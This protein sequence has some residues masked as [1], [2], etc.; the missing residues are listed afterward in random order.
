MPFNMNTVDG[1]GGGGGVYRP[2]TTAIYTGVS[3]MDNEYYSIKVAR[4]VDDDEDD[5]FGG[6]RHQWT[7]PNF[8][9][10][11]QTHKTR[12]NC[13]TTPSSSAASCQLDEIEALVP[14]PVVVSRSPSN[15]FPFPV[16]PGGT[17][18]LDQQEKVRVR[19]VQNRG[20]VVEEPPM[21]L[22]SNGQ[23]VTP[24][25]LPFDCDI[26]SGFSSYDFIRPSP[27]V[28]HAS[29]LDKGKSCPGH[30]SKLSNISQSPSPT[31][32]MD[33]VERGDCTCESTSNSKSHKTPPPFSRTRHGSPSA[34][35]SGGGGGG[36][37]LTPLM[38]P[39]IINDSHKIQVIVKPLS[40][41]KN[42]QGGSN[43]HLYCALVF[44]F[45]ASLFFSLTLL[46]A[47]VLKNRDHHPISIAFWRYLGILVPSI[48]LGLFYFLRG[49]KHKVVGSVWPIQDMDKAAN[50]L[51]LLVKIDIKLKLTTFVDFFATCNAL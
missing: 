6:Y 35:G 34:R 8:H 1:S 44:G 2:T 19:L 24:P 23:L 31:Y 20:L 3:P 4:E 48:P 37:S 18:F 16:T 32:L 47:K 25:D 11:P 5:H 51:A 22:D 40:T 28:S 10:L 36:S 12:L 50:A 14:V 13:S 7:P 46:L 39:D 9:M 15:V 21:V 45:S 43:I 49:K 33:D 29:C 27:I 41:M 38:T 26:R 30:S 17:G 42:R